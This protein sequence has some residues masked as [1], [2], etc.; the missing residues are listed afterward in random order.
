MSRLSD[1]F[2]RLIASRP[3]GDPD[4]ALAVARHRAATARTRQRALVGLGAAAAAVVL[5]VAVVI[6]AGD[7]P[8]DDVRTGPADSTTTSEPTTSTTTEVAPP[9][10]PGEA[11]L[12]F[13]P[14]DDGT[15]AQV[16]GVPR[17]VD[18]DQPLAATIDALLDGPTPEEGDAGLT[19]WFSET[20]ANRLRHVEV[21]DSTAH[22]DF[23]DFSSI[24]P[25]ASTSCGSTNLLAQLDATVTQFDGV[26]QAIYSFDGSPEA[27]YAWLQRDVP[28]GA[29]P[30]LAY[31]GADA[32]Y[33]TASG[34][35][36][37]ITFGTRG[38]RVVTDEPAELAY[39]VGTGFVAYQRLDP[40]SYG[41]PAGDVGPV[42][43]WALP[44]ADPSS[45]ADPFELPMGD[46][47]D[48][49]TLLDATWVAARPVALVSERSG[50]TP[51]DTTEAL[52]EI[53][54][55]TLDRTVVVER[56]AWESSHRDA[57]LLPNGD[58]VGLIDTEAR[59][60]LVRWT[61][62]VDE[63]VWT[64][65]L[66]VDLADGLA[67]GGGRLS[68]VER[69]VWQEEGTAMAVADI[70]LA[71][72]SLASPRQFTVGAGEGGGGGSVPRCHDWWTYDVLVC[73]VAAGAPIT[74]DVAG[75]SATV[76]PLDLPTDAKAT[77]IR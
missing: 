47:A 71:T 74:I 19:S 28:D 35:G 15:C 50:S 20:T 61:P 75:P 76:E 48:V 25:N 30:D 68:L 3:A 18:A 54:L 1:A 8:P 26:D 39:A 13:S 56:A 37:V 31:E 24:I 42:M 9:T 45:P 27:F 40:N 62:G 60:D 23:D 10:E 41:G 58:V 59:T 44:P 22:V 73:S 63:P 32:G 70:D 72:G 33:V 49:A 53:D 51:D 11:Q 65:D 21:A 7:G 77:P 38:Q 52:V 64:N 29:R 57:R 2:D 12:F 17:R 69:P 36:V 55:F 43:A 4:D 67:G 66:G 46:G 34:A 6:A 16:T 5:V 14:A